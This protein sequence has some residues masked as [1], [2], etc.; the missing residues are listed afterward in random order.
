MPTIEIASLYSKGLNL[1]QDDFEVTIL[2]QRK[3]ETQRRNFSEVLKKQNGTMV[4]IGNPEIRDD[5]S[6]IFYASELV[7]WD[8]DPVEVIHL[9]IFDEQDVHCSPGANQQKQFKFLDK[10]KTDI[11][12]LLATALAKS[13]VRKC[14]LLTNY[15]FGPDQNRQEIVRTISSFW[16]RHDRE[17]LV[18]NTM[19][20]LRAS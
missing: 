9:P 18:F 17:G 6:N 5:R 20:E 8:F 13:P 4:H 3:L 15:Y 19:Y 1:K 2:E 11:D 12:R 10:F 14:Y 7:D 16:D